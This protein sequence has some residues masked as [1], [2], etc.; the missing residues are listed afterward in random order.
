MANPIATIVRTRTRLARLAMSEVA[1]ASTLPIAVTLTL[2]FAIELID[3]ALWRRWG[4]VL[5]PN[6]GATL[7]IAA[8]VAAGGEVLMAAVVAFVAWRRAANFEETARQIDEF[9]GA[10]QE[11]LTLASLADPDRPESTARR[12]PLFATL[13]RHVLTHLE[14]FD[15]RSAFRLNLTRSLRRAAAL[16]VAIAIVI[17]LATLLTIRTPTALQAATYALRDFAN[18]IDTP[19]APPALRQLANVAR[20]VAGDLENPQLPP[21]QKLAELR[22]VKQ[23]IARLEPL[24]TPAQAGSGNSSGS[25]KGAGT[26]SGTGEGEGTGSGN[27]KDKSA[28]G[29]GQGAQAG[30]KG[31]GSGDNQKGKDGEPSVKLQ[32][33][34]AKAEAKLEQAS[35]ETPQKLASAK[36][37]DNKANGISPAPGN[38]AS[39]GGAGKPD[40]SGNIK[41]P[42]QSKLAQSQAPPGGGDTVAHKGDK[43]T[44]GDTH[45]GD[46]PQARRLRAI[47]QARRARAANRYQERALRHFPAAGENAYR[48]RRW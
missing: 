8:F 47:L 44:Q 30:G 38:S 7:R 35:G 6:R 39:S 29:T 17:M 41:L 45:L 46:F 10:H 22:A 20:N 5:E 3:A 27:G 23:E 13:W 36:D 14:K 18:S 11:V 2:A 1:V 19:G 48:G 4:Y 9:L 21:Q 34:L 12:T 25:G 24:Q 43:G 28:Q 40:G 42:D 32:N 16:A 37:Q 33:N 31:A 15:P 26:G